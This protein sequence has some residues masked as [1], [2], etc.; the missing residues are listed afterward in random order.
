MQS[1]T[2]QLGRQQAIATFSQPRVR[3]QI[4]NLQEKGKAMNFANDGWVPQEGSNSDPN[5][6]GDITTTPQA[7]TAA[8]ENLVAV[9]QDL[10]YV[11]RQAMVDSLTKAHAA[12]SSTPTLQKFSRKKK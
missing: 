6:H 11:T 4:L 12:A 3:S 10:N 2:N 5:N 7:S 9:F 1:A 8:V